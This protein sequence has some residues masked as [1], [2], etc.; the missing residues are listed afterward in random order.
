MSIETPCIAVC[1]IDPQTNLCYG[2]GRTMP[3]IARWPRMSSAERRAIMAALPRR[4][5]DAGMELPKPRP[6]RAP[7]TD[8]LS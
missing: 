4:M 1:L 6:R 7:A 3:E 2:C 8:A 5:T